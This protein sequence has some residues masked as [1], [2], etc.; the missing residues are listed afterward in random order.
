MARHA[1]E[2]EKVIS[3]MPFEAS[4]SMYQPWYL[5]KNVKKDPDFSWMD[6]KNRVRL[7]AVE[8]RFHS[9]ADSTYDKVVDMMERIKGKRYVTDFVLL[10]QREIVLR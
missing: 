5:R 9:E 1:Q 8:D 6:V 10:Y 3:S 2:A 4:A 7:F